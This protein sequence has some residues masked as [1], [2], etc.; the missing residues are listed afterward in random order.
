M[1]RAHLIAGL[2]AVT[3]LL[4]SLPAISASAPAPT[5]T[6]QLVN[7]W[8]FVVRSQSLLAD[9]GYAIEY[10]YEFQDEEELRVRGSNRAEI[11]EGQIRTILD[12]DPVEASL[13]I[14]G[15]DY[16]LTINRD[17]DRLVAAWQVLGRAV[18]ADLPVQEINR[19][20]SLLRR[21]L[22]ETKRRL[23]LAQFAPS[24]TQSINLLIR[25]V[26]ALALTPTKDTPLS[27]ELRRPGQPDVTEIL[28]TQVAQQRWEITY[29]GGQL[30]IRITPAD[31]PS[32]TVL[33][34]TYRGGIVAGTSGGSPLSRAEGFRTAAK[35]FSFLQSTR[36]YF[37]TASVTAAIPTLRR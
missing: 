33:S 36:A 5:I 35:A 7:I 2:I 37:G 13:H 1:L 29:G 16:T 26:E 25:H 14:R 4:S 20:W 28:V 32:T 12:G 11:L 6:L 19:R 22:F 17:R 8:S 31:D 24:R 9:R 21:L 15:E 10:L 3:L 23:G 27:Y 30:S 34:I 18:A